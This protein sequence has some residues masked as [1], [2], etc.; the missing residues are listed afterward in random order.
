MMEGS[1]GG[2]AKTVLIVED[3][4]LNLKLFCDLLAAH[5]YRTEPVRDGRAVLERARMIRPD[6]VVMD[7]QLPHIS[8]LAL[9]EAI[10]RD[11]TLDTIPIMAVT[12]YAARGDEERIRQAGVD[13]YIAKPVTVTRFLVSVRALIGDAVIAQPA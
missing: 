7:I 10:K 5:G 1:D 2:I 13:S 12:A 4:E 6:L 11:P 9:I 3:N 8:G